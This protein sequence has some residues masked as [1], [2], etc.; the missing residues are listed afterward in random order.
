MEFIFV[1]NLNIAQHG[2]AGGDD[3]IVV[4]EHRNILVAE[5]CHVF[6]EAQTGREFFGISLPVG[7][8]TLRD[9]ERS[10][11]ILDLSLFLRRLEI[12]QHLNCFSQAHVICILR[13]I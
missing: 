12:G 9:N 3:H 2:A 13:K 1:Q 6:E 11:F 4:V 10:R 8:E 5:I 7:N